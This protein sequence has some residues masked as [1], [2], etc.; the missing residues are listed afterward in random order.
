MGELYPKVDVL[1]NNAG[2]H[3]GERKLTKQGIETNFGVNYLAHF[4]LTNLMVP[5][6]RNGGRVVNVSSM[7]YKDGKVNL[8][9]INYEEQKW[10]GL[11]AYKNAKLYQVLFSK[12]FEK[13]YP[14]SRIKAVSLNPGFVRTPG[15]AKIFGNGIL[16]YIIHPLVW[17]FSK[18]MP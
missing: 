17:Y 5:L 10:S 4:Y 3:E 16:S 9:D 12:E 18:S 6:L 13:K 2:M 7:I 8:D 1:I 14:D 15:V 11:Q